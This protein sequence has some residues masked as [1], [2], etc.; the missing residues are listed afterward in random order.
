MA[1]CAL[2]KLRFVAVKGFEGDTPDFSSVLGA[3]AA[4]RCKAAVSSDVRHRVPLCAEDVEATDDSSLFDEDGYLVGLCG[5][6]AVLVPSPT[7]AQT[8][9]SIHDIGTVLRHEAITAGGFRWRHAATGVGGRALSSS[10]ARS[11]ASVPQPGGEV[12]C[13]ATTRLRHDAFDATAAAGPSSSSPRA[14]AAADGERDLTPS[15]RL[16]V[17]AVETPTR[18]VT[19]HRY[20]RRRPRADAPR[21]ASAAAGQ[22]AAGP[23]RR[24]VL[25]AGSRAPEPSLSRADSRAPETGARSPVGPFVLRAVRQTGRCRSGVVQ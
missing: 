3:F 21:G 19:R 5:K 23:R 13:A 1:C 11:S 14:A 17:V 16:L 6:H 4:R 24:A 15:W 9:L 12:E 20:D 25:R 8:A 22:R 10:A 7:A 2:H 18:D